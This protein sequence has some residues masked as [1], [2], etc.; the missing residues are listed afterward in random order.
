MIEILPFTEK[1]LKEISLLEKEIFS[2]PWGEKALKDYLLSPSARGYVLSDEKKILSYALFSTLLGEGELLRIGTEKSALRQGFAQMLLKH[3]FLNSKKEN[4]EK[5]FLEVR[6]EN[7]AARS[8]YEK[9]GFLLI[10][11]RKGYYKNPNDDACIYQKNQ[12]GTGTV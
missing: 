5:I 11:T 10:G 9:M 1:H 7:L 6:K 8:L 12:N 3:Y 2:D 4:V